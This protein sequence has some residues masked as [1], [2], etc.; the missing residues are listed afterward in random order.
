MD[1]VEL[2]ENVARSAD[3]ATTVLQHLEAGLR[4]SGFASASSGYRQ[5]ADVLLGQ[6]GWLESHDVGELRPR[7]DAIGR[8]AQAIVG[9]LAPVYDALRRLSTMAGEDTIAAPLAD[10]G[11]PTPTASGMLDEADVV[12]RIMAALR[13]GER[14]ASFLR[15]AV[16][17]D[18]RPLAS[19]LA[20]LQAE[21]AVTKRTASGRPLFRLTL[22]G[23]ARAA[24][25]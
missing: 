22:G 6:R 20:R 18:R 4:R 14:S 17:L 23:A 24:E 5:L 21:G 25:R 1:E 16:G 3:T 7:F 11:P 15:T 10:A 13:D 12:E 19:M 8:Q 9:M 2:R